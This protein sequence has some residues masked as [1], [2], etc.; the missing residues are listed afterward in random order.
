MIFF[1]ALFC[2]CDGFGF[3]LYTVVIRLSQAK[4]NAHD[5]E[6]DELSYSTLQSVPDHRQLNSSVHFF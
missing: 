5:C 2:C 1:F 4:T 3:A 6:L